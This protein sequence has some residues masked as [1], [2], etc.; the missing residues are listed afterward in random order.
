M[1]MSH[2][3]HTT[4]SVKPLNTKAMLVRL[5]T[6]R[7]STR[8]RDVA[9][10]A[11][12]RGQLRDESLVVSATL[13]RDKN[14]AVRRLLNEAGNVYSYHK[15]HTL[16]WVDRGPRLLPVGQYDEYCR[17]MRRMI[18]NMESSTARLMPDYDAYV[19]HDMLDRGSRAAI[20]DYPSADEFKAAMQFKF[21][22]SPLPDASHFLFDVS[23]EDKAALNAQLEEARAGVQ[24]DMIERIR[25]PLLHLVS[26]LR[27][28]IGEPG[29]VFRDSAVEN[30]VDSL[31]TV[32]SLAM[33]DQVVL[34]MVRDVRLAIRP[35]AVAMNSLRES[36]VD[37]A[38][39]AAKLEAVASK[40]AWMLGGAA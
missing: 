3:P 16:P 30:I 39:A 22:L 32:E 7:P 37:R 27:V 15:L 20:T 17:E 36:P 34:D 33:D 10:E 31:A 24:A 11:T 23:D 28:E 6:S 35:H 19:G 9:A 2:V 29:A 25:T 38:T 1:D 21:T 14:C 26:K 40:M 18:L 12:I 8:R 5:T 4:S 13:F